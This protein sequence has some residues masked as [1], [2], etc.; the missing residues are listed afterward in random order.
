MKG[1]G[2]WWI[3]CLGEWGVGRWGGWWFVG[4]IIDSFGRRFVIRGFSE[5]KFWLSIVV[6]VCCFFC[7]V[8]LDFIWV[9]V[10]GWNMNFF[11]FWLYWK[12]IS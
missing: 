9:K 11:F 10:E 7:V 4:D 2:G 8:V 1:V 5:S 6:I 12:V 3:E